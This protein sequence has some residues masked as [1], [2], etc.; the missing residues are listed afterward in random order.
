MIRLFPKRNP[1]THQAWLDMDEAREIWASFPE[2]PGEKET[3]VSDDNLTDEQT[4]WWHKFHTHTLKG[5][6]SEHSIALGLDHK[7]TDVDF[8]EHQ[9]KPLP[10]EE[11]IQ[12]KK[13]REAALIQR[14]ESWRKKLEA[15]FGK[16]LFKIDTKIINFILSKRKKEN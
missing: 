15:E 16:K 8:E 4:S 13:D 2:W 10:T 12:K 1:D 7:L 5:E 9:G 6:R 3:E 14:E 11:E